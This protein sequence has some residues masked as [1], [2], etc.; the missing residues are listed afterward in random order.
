MLTFAEL[1]FMLESA[2]VILRLHKG[3]LT[4]GPASCLTDELRAN[5]R[6]HRERMITARCERCGAPSLGFDFCDDC[7]PFG[8][9]EDDGA[10]A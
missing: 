7:D 1:R 9:P 6:E 10:R 2:G 5:I 4:A 3:R 8:P